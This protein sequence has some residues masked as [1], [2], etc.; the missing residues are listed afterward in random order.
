ML[1]SF[2]ALEL[3]L[4]V[5]VFLLAALELAGIL[6][7]R[8]EGRSQNLSRVITHAFM[9][10]L[11]LLYGYY[12]ISYYPLEASEAGI[13]TFG[14][15]VFNWTYLLL[16]LLVTL[17]AGWEAVGLLRARRQ[18]LTQNVS[19]L[20]SHAVM[21]VLLLAMMGLSGK[22]WDLY[23]DRLEVTYSKSIPGSE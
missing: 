23:L 20:V 18:G 1:N 6:R 22:K 11:L 8:R 3:L 5:G 4:A 13:E 17:L 16:A 19:R 10:A 15:P 9:L 7:A 2:T 21:L 12:A 14:T